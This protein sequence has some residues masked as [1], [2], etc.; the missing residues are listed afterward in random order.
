METP[1]DQPRFV[2]CRCQ[3]CDGNIEFDAN[4]LVEENSIVPCPH[5]GLETKIFVPYQQTVTPHEP[6]PSP[7]PAFV[8]ISVSSSGV[9]NDSKFTDSNHPLKNDCATRK[10]VAYLNYMGVSNADQ[11]SKLEAAKLI[12]ANSFVGGAKSTAEF[13]RL[14][15]HQERWNRERLIL[16]PEVYAA[17]LKQFLRDELPTTLHSYVRQQIVG[18][19]EKLTKAKIR[20][21]IEALTAENCGWWHNIDFQAVFLER[22]AQFYPKCCDGFRG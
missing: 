19:P 7:P 8:T 16:H 14:R 2:V 9:P 21:V 13:N 20:R 1:G 18:A 22:L 12:E 11:L 3:Y 6:S 5:C 17:E 10:Q 15:S 4:H